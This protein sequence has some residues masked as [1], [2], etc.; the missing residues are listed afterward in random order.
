MDI[1]SGDSAILRY[2]LKV[3]EAGEGG[4]EIAG[5][6]T[7][8]WYN[9]SIFLT[10]TS[11]V[12]NTPESFDITPY[13]QP[14]TNNISVAVNASV[15]GDITMPASRGWTVKLVDLYFNW[16]FETS[17]INTRAFTDS[18]TVYGDVEKYMHLAIDGET[19]EH[20][21]YIDD[22]A[23]S[24]YPGGKKIEGSGRETKETIPVLSHGVHRLTRWLTATV[25]GVPVPPK[26][27]T[28][29]TIF[30]DETKTEAVVSADTSD[31]T[32]DQYSTKKIMFIVADPTD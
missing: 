31:F 23:H 6:A 16:P 19:D 2:R 12:H 25:N 27:K 28:V 9:N 20:G 3:V 30:F 14:G 26:Y 8:R 7:A 29:E 17:R 18:Y 24:P 4:E 11:V 32:M 13:L 22:D 15:G 10:S 21:D 1:V 5:T